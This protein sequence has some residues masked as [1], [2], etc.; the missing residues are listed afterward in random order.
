MAKSIYSNRTVTD[1][2]IV[3]KYTLLKQSFYNCLLYVV[4]YSSNMPITE[5]NV[6]YSIISI[7]LSTILIFEPG[8]A[9]G[10][11]QVSRN[12]SSL[13]NWHSIPIHSNKTVQINQ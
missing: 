4:N 1:H 10:V 11:S 7:I 12:Q 2:L 9:L 3:N 5:H 13:L 6:N 8:V